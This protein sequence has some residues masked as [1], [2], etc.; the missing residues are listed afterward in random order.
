MITTVTLNAMLDKTVRLKALRRGTIHRAAEMSMVAGG[1]GINVSRQLTVLGMAT[2]ATGF[3]GGETGS[4]IRRSMNRDGIRHDFV[5]VAQL[6]REG[7]TYRESNGMVTAVFEPSEPVTNAEAD[8]LAR[9]VA[10]LS[11]KSAWIVCS[12]S[13]PCDASD[14]LFAAMIADAR[15]R[16]VKTVLDSYGLSLKRAWAA[17]PTIVKPNRHE[18]AMTFGKSLRGIRSVRAALDEAL[19]LG[20]ECAVM[21]DGAGVTYAATKQG[22]WKIQNPRIRAVNPVGSGDAMVAGILYGL[23]QGWDFPRSLVFGS[24]AGVANAQVWEVAGSG[25]DQI[26]RVEPNIRLESLAW[27]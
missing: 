20:I 19:N 14:D 11:G 1:K 2:V 12:G 3:L 17:A 8:R 18:Y 27:H 23:K 26:T 24:A 5:E 15:S 4:L 7:V 13:S 16:G 10:S 21:T 25:L 9:K 22:Y 6:T